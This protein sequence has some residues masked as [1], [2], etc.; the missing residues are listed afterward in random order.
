MNILD[1][2]T[3]RRI[4]KVALRFLKRI[5]KQDA[6]HILSLLDGICYSERTPEDYEAAAGVLENGKYGVT[7]FLPHLR[8]MPDVFLLITVAH[9]FA[10]VFLE[11]KRPD[12][13]EDEQAC[14]EAVHNQLKVW[15]VREE[16]PTIY[17]P[18]KGK[19]FLEISIY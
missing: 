9:E 6:E 12:T 19:P 15:A 14:E 8:Y 11:H 2:W 18:S 17:F 5:P 4:A 16:Y 3:K 7:F 10:H 13:P 1:R